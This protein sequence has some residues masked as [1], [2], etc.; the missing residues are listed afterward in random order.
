MFIVYRLTLSSSL[1]IVDT[2]SSLF[3]HC[4]PHLQKSEHAVPC[5]LQPQYFL[6]QCPLQEHLDIEGWCFVFC[7]NKENMVQMQY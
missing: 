6:K 2:G 5:L 3:L 4:S 1:H 7:N